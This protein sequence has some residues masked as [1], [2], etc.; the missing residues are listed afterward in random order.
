MQRAVLL[1]AAGRLAEARAALD[2]CLRL[3]PRSA[4]GYTLRA[5][6]RSRADPAGALADLDQALTLEPDHPR[7][8]RARGLASMNREDYEAA[9]ADFVVAAESLTQDAELLFWLGE[10]RFQLESYKAALPV[11]E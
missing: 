4:E 5:L 11:L 2:E 6:L 9:E 3:D 1:E 7:A 8:R 10:V